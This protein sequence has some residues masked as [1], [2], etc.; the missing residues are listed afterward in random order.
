M[1]ANDLAKH[2]QGVDL[3]DLPSEMNSKA[4]RAGLVVVI[5]VSRDT[6]EFYGAIDGEADVPEG[7]PIHIDADGLLPDAEE[8]EDGTD[9]ELRAYYDR[10]RMAYLIDAEVDQHGFPWSFTTAIPHHRF[11]VLKDGARYCRGIVFD[12][13]SIGGKHGR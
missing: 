5:G 1:K 13:A 2:L 12:Y 7:G 4:R 10:K 9:A 3:D 11:V 8:M 6:V